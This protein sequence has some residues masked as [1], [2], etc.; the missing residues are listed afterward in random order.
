MALALPL[1]SAVGGG[2]RGRIEMRPWKIAKM[3]RQAFGFVPVGPVVPPIGPV[4]PPIAPGLGAPII[5]PVG[6]LAPPPPLGLGGY[7]YGGGY[8]YGGGYG[9]YGYGPSGYY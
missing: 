8:E 2:G 5:P 7:G 9:G 4:G 1:L 6:A 3:R